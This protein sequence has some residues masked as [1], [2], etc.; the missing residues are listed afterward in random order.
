MRGVELEHVEACTDRQP[1]RT[2]ELVAHLVHV[3]ATHRARHGKPCGVRE[4]RRSARLPSVRAEREILPLPWQTRRTLSSRVSELETDLCRR[5]LVHKVNH[6][7]PVFGVFGRVQTRAAERDSRL[8]R[9]THHLRHD[10]RGA[11]KRARAK[12]HEMEIV[13][14]AV[15]SAVHVHRGEHDTVLQRH[16]AQAKGREHRWRRLLRRQRTVAERCA[17]REPPLDTFHV[18]RVAQAKILVAHALAAR[19]QA[20]RELLWRQASVSLDVLEPLHGVA[21]SVLQAQRLGDSLVLIF[22]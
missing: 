2:H 8:G 16:L 22:L 10:E 3:G 20:V 19:E 14:R 12:M 4:R 11:A 9:H 17:A 5:P 1:R 7:A 21:R 18:A 15:A 6:A 13:R